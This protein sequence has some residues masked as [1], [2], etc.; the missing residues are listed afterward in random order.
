MK[1]VPKIPSFFGGVDKAR[2]ETQSS[3]LF[4][5]QCQA[6]HTPPFSSNESHNP[7][8]P[9]SPI[10]SGIRSGGTT[11]PRGATNGAKAGI[12]RSAGGSRLCAPPAWQERDKTDRPVL[13]PCISLVF[14]FSFFLILPQPNELENNYGPGNQS[15]H[16]KSSQIV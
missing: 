2:P 1:V 5:N 9:M 4:A 16:V 7:H 11:T 10:R 12:C 3:I 15:Q 8:H 13:L 6:K 14:F